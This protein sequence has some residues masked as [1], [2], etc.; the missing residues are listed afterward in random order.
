[1][2]GFSRVGVRGVAA[3]GSHLGGRR[4]VAHGG[5]DASIWNVADAAVGCPQVLLLVLF[6]VGAAPRPAGLALESRGALG[7]EP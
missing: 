3:Y 4:S 5:A 1:M 6:S 7:T 2:Q